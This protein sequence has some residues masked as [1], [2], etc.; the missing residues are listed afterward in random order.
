[1]SAVVHVVQKNNKSQGGKEWAFIYSLIF[2]HSSILLSHFKLFFHTFNLAYI[3]TVK[4][5]HVHM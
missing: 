1:M 5:V 3:Y 4:S 2:T